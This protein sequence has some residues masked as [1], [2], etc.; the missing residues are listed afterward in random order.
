MKLVKVIFELFAEDVSALR[1]RDI[2]LTTVLLIQLVCHGETNVLLFLEEEVVLLNKVVE[3]IGLHHHVLWLISVVVVLSKTPINPKTVISDPTK[4]VTD[5]RHQCL[6]LVSPHGLSGGG[7]VNQSTDNTR[8]RVCDL[9]WLV[10]ANEEEGVDSLRVALHT[11]LVDQDR[12][13]GN[14]AVKKAISFDTREVS[15]LIDGHER[16]LTEGTCSKLI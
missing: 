16:T 15:I 13:M 9:D 2:T 12:L 11:L 6:I 7:D 4:L 3:H 5:L 1:V 8:L 10:R 14:H